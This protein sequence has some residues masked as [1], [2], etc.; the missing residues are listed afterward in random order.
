[1]SMPRIN[2]VV[3]GHKD[4]GKST[5]IGRLLY[6]S[7]AV[8]EQ[9][10]S[11]IRSELKREEETKFEFAFLLDSLEEERK[12][13]LT[14]DIMQ[15]PFKSKRYLYTIIDC[16]GHR[17]FIKNML[18]GASQAD[19]AIL[20]VSAKEGI[21]DQT[22]QHIFLSK[23]LGIK[24]LVVA[25]NKMDE[26]SYGENVYRKTCDELERILRD[27]GYVNVPMVPIS[28]ERGDNVYRKTGRMKWYKEATLIDTLDENITPREPP[29]D[30][31]LRGIVQDVYSYNK[32][33]VIIC[34]I[35]TGIL[36]S[37]REVVFNPSGKRGFL[38]KILSFDSVKGEAEP[39]ESVGLIID[40]I[41]TVERGEVLS[42]PENQP[43]IVRKFTAE[44]ILF[45][46]RKIKEGDEIVIRY[47]T[48]EK[49]CKVRRIL[50]EIDPVNFII[51]SE[52]P[53]TLE[54]ES[55]GEVE[56]IALEPL[57]L[58]EYSNFPELGRFV[59][60]GKKGAVGAGIVL[61]V[62]REDEAIVK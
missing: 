37:G 46:N 35:E 51:R 49:K 32:E 25:V 59:I 52:N 16:P 1:M 15:I 39:G 4:H 44:I 30:K 22:R 11:E 54:K 61:E 8:S 27:L 13:K 57:C 55:V 42:Y 21:Q 10:L 18:T 26:V 36:K 17:E 50:S 53:E 9:K 43:R 5:L 28:A 62:Y 34:K 47:G 14:I 7:K 29:S 12:G 41:D 31:P 19:A 45:S 33:K 23:I 3:V 48:A 40:G 2:L 38:K 60:E 24:Q 6:D 58:E 56:F 20:V